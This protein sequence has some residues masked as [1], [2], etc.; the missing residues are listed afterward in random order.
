MCQVSE[1]AGGLQ[2]PMALAGTRALWAYMNVSLSH[3][4]YSVFTAGPGNRERIVAEMSIEGGL[5][6]DDGSRLATVPLAGHGGL[7]VFADINTDEGSPSGVYRLVGDRVQHVAGTEN[8]FAVAV[9]AGGSLSLGRSRADACA[10]TLR[11]GHRMRG[12]SRS[13]RAAT[14]AEARGGAGSSW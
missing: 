3:Y 12:E 13:S 8:A 11:R 4:N 1:S 9:A 6:D 2:P 10:T 5:E 14:R 7:L